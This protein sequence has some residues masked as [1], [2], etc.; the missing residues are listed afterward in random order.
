MVIYQYLNRKLEN[1]NDQYRYA[2]MQKAKD[3]QLA[4]P[5]FECENVKRPNFGNI[6]TPEEL[7]DFIQKLLQ[8]NNPND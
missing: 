1:P 5:D 4:I 2:L 8:K 6:R 7:D 3:N